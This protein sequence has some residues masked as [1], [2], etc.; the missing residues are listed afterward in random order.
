MGLASIAVKKVVPYP[1]P[2]RFDRFLFIGPH[3]DDIEIGERTGGRF[4]EPSPMLSG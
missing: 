2:E 4:E 3:P 1:R